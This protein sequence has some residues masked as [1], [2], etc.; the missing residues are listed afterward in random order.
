MTP[1]ELEGWRKAT[2]LSAE[3]LDYGVSLIKKG[4]NVVEVLDKIEDMIKEKGGLP[5]FPAQISLNDT[6]AHYCHDD[7]EET[8]LEDE[9]VKLDMGVQI[10]GYLG[11]NARSVDLSGQN[12][13]LI[14]ATREALKEAIRVVA[15]G[16][17]LGEIGQSIQDVIMSY[18]LAPVRN[19]SGH[20]VARYEIHTKPT[21][22]NFN[23]GD[24]TKLVVGQ[25]IAIEPFATTGTGA[26]EEAGTSGVF[27][28]QEE[29]PVRLQT[30]RDILKEA[31]QYGGLPFAKRWMVRK[32][33]R[34][35]TEIALKQL[36]QSGA[37]HQFPPLVEKSHGLVSQHEHT[38]YVNENGCEVLTK[39]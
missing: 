20:G 25:T 12:K 26:I 27:M 33:G 17:T 32:F 35:K 21:I 5:S 18:G 6:A 22:P 8:I 4:A 24:T 29:K 38:L 9:V 2:K 16:I 15:P 13:E 23:N 30:A 39:F 19:L 36:V 10:D 11:D 3:C 28:V 37:V 34:M 1:E 31:R 14:D 7:G